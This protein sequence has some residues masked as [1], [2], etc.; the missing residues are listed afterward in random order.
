MIT[1]APSAFVDRLE[2]IIEHW[3]PVLPQHLQQPFREAFR[4]LGAE[5]DGALNTIQHIWQRREREYAFDEST[6][7]ARRRPFHDHLV[8]LLRMP[9]SPGLSAIGVLFLDLD[10]LKRVNDTYGHAVGDRALAAVG[11]IIRD[12]L[13]V[14]C[15]IDLVTRAEDSDLSVSRHGGDEFLVALELKDPQDI[16]VVAPRIKQRVEDP[17]SQQVRGYLAPVPLTVSVGAVVYEL[18]PTPP[19]ASAPSVAR[20]LVTAADEQMYRSKQDGRV[21]V[22]RATFTDKL[23]IDRDHARRLV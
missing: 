23:Q 4:P 20:D 17:D 22:A 6:G 7:L 14:E 3:V 18:P 9:S 2:A 12:A 16:T 5:H 19:S 21:H 15:H 1:R 13:R 8:N 10:N 11:S